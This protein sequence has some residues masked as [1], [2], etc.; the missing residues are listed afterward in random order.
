MTADSVAPR[1]LG[2]LRDT[3]TEVRRV[4]TADSSLYAGAVSLILRQDEQLVVLR[5]GLEEIAARPGVSVFTQAV[6][7]GALKRAERS[8]QC[9]PTSA[10]GW[11]RSGM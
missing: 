4:P 10:A 7:L 8:D 3:G 5:A 6:A 1:P 11:A 9:G 2:R